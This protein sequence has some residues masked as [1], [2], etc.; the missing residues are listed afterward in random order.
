[1]T[2]YMDTFDRKAKGFTLI[3]KSL[4]HQF[5]AKVCCG[6]SQDRLTGPKVLHEARHRYVA[7]FAGTLPQQAKQLYDQSPQAAIFLLDQVS[8]KLVKLILHI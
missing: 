3:I 2:C 6:A 5:C 7:Y 4:S 8:S 1:M